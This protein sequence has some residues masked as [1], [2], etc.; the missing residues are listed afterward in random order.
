MRGVHNFLLR[1]FVCVFSR[2]SKWNTC[3]ARLFFARKKKKKERKENKN[4]KK[5]K[6]KE[7]TKRKKKKRR[8][9]TTTTVAFY[10]YSWLCRFRSACSFFRRFLQPLPTIFPSLQ[11]PSL[12]AFNVRPTNRNSPLSSAVFLKNT[13]SISY[14]AERG[15]FVLNKCND[16]SL[17]VRACVSNK[18]EQTS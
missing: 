3:L 4:Q 5:K 11:T 18:R 16:N 12:Y 6:K 9:R 8:K 17:C 10:T 15:V 7:N 2:G 14:F 13:R 1:N